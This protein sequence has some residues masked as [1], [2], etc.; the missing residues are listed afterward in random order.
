MTYSPL[1]RAAILLLSLNDAAKSAILAQLS[2]DEV[3]LLINATRK[4]GVVPSTLAQDITHDFAQGLSTGVIGAENAIT[5][6]LSHERQTKLAKPADTAWTRLESLPDALLAEHLSNERAEVVAVLLSKIT[7]EKAASL[8]ALF[9]QTFSA[10][11]LAHLARLK[12]V[13]DAMIAKAADETI[14]SKL[15]SLDHSAQEQQTVGLLEMLS[16]S[17]ASG[18]LQTLALE[19][20]DLALMLANDMLTFPKIMQYE[21]KKL[22]NILQDVPPLTLAE[23]LAPSSPAERQIMLMHLSKNAAYMVEDELELME[24]LPLEV[25][26][27]AR[28][29]IVSLARL[30]LK[31]PAYA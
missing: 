25:S 19:D 23:S 5:A 15:K 24:D 10:E 2:D 26:Q 4:I 31:E 14:V 6:H 13:N 17:L 11:L 29:W 21:G 28:A 18:V 9:N 30:K 7:K 16:P 22:Q 1:D 8:L 20:K 27:K 12:P 3:T